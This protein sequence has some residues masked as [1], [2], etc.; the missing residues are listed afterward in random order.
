VT[1]QPS[2]DDER[3]VR[4]VSQH[5]ARA[6]FVA[7]YEGSP[8]AAK[9]AFMRAVSDALKA[10]LLAAREVNGVPHLWFAED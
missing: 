1:L 9:K 7:S 2:A 3:A 8:N 4:A 10:K 6:E 5:K